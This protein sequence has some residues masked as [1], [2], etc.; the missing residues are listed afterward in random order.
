MKQLRSMFLVIICFVAISVVSVAQEDSQRDPEFEQAIYDKLSQ[1]DPAAV[2][3]FIAAT[4]AMDSDNLG[5]ARQ[6]YED[7]LALVPE[8]SDALRRLSYVVAEAGDAERSIELARQAHELDPSPLNQSALARALLTS[9]DEN[10]WREGL[11]LA[12][13]A[14]AS[15]PADSTYQYMFLLGGIR[16]QNIRI[17]DQASTALI[18]LE[19]ELA[20]AHF[21]QGLIAANNE[22]W[23]RAEDELIMA[24]DLGWPAD[25]INE[26]LSEDISSNASRQ[27]TEKRILTLGPQ[28]V[29]VWLAGIVILFVVGMILSRLTLATVNRAKVTGSLAPSSTERVVRMAYRVVILISAIYFFIS[30]P[31]VGLIAL[32]LIGGIFYLF[33][34]AGR[35]P[36]RLAAFL[37]IAALATLWAIMRGL[38]SVF[39]RPPWQDPGQSL[40]RSEAPDLWAVTEEVAAKVGTRAIDAI[41]LVPG[42]T[43][44]VMERGNLIT[45]MS[46]KGARYLILGLGALSE[47]TLGQLKAILAHEYGHFSNRDTAGG[48]FALQVRISM[49]ETARH[50]AQSGQASWI[51]PVWL[52]LNIF[53]HAFMRITLGASRLQEVLADRF[54]VVSYGAKNFIDGLSHV[55]RRSL[56]FETAVNIEINDML[57]EKRAMANLYTLP[58]IEQD[59]QEKL[60]QLYEQIFQRPTD[61]YD[62]HPAFVDRVALA[63]KI[64]VEADHSS[65]ND[66]KLATELLPDIEQFQSAMTTQVNQNFQ[67]QQRIMAQFQQAQRQ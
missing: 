45:K 62:S 51:N 46:D 19:P 8:S 24:R 1:V 50:L 15:D 26:I 40:S 42:A 12:E 67:Q 3:L 14:V 37:A 64:V 35:I 48:D 52:F 57:D 59:T 43:I 36:V 29:G 61:I 56:E 7:V 16:N 47:M 41:Y 49:S 27:R 58:P 11:Q 28:I 6:N 21:Y 63:Q 34:S 39:S 66:S 22:D 32:G 13:S 55:I 53:N 65:P 54:A 10:G 9:N 33:L 4:E 25:E 60:D 2:P 5:V 18:E 17:I 30:L 23:S 20:M 38:M 44:A 31:I